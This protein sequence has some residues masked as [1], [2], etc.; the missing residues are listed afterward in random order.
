MIANL[1]PVA[2]LPLL[3]ASMLVLVGGVLAG[4]ARMGML[5]SSLGAQVAGWHGALLI[6]GFFASV[7]GL[8]RAVALGH[9][10]WYSAPAAS[11]L[12]GLLILAGHPTLSVVTCLIG[13]VILLIGSLQVVRTLPTLFTVTLAGGAFALVLGN[14]VWWISGVVAF[15]VPLWF[16]FLVLTIAGERLELTRLRPPQPASRYL[17]VILLASCALAAGVATGHDLDGGPTRPL[18]A[19]LLA[20]AL[21]LMRYDVAR[22]NLSQKGLPRFVAISLLVGYGQLAFGAC[23]GLDGA[24]TLGHPW[25]D[26]ALHAVLLGFVFS[27]VMGHAPVIFPAVMR[28]R[29][30]YHPAFYAP[31]AVLQGA[32]LLRELGVLAN[33]SS[34]QRTGAIGNAGALVLLVLTLLVRIRIGKREK[35]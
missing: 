28:V 19:V 11:G 13:S 7:I 6:A 12:G 21:W 2:R 1:P 3:I 35:L 30:P 27:M 34:L 24:F 31:L 23:L 4:L 18:A 9:P 33:V 25:R 17:F 15:A 14:V 32:L 8:E 10:I 20:F 22:H 29:I 5:V 16:V 26:A